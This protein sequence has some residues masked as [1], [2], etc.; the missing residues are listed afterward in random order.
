MKLF[1]TG[2][3]LLICLA[4]H[5]QGIFVVHFDFNKH[6]LTK[7]SRLQLDSLLHAHGPGLQEYLIELQGHC[8]A[9]GSGRY[10][11]WLSEKRINTVRQYLVT[12][13]TATHFANVKAY[14]ERV[15]LNSNATAGERQLNRRVEISLVKINPTG[16]PEPSLKEKIADSSTT[17]GTNIVLRNINFVGGMHEFLPSSSAALQELRDAMRAYPTLVIEVQ[18]HIC[19]EPGD[20]DGTD[21][22]TGLPNLSE[23]RAKAVQDF[24]IKNGI[25]PG[26]ITYKGFGHS[27]PLYIYPEKTEE[28]KIA[29]RRVEI[30]I[31]KK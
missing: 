25:G 28:E 17:P 31:V 22:G 14:G 20:K 13:G 6:S 11:Q 9:I 3:V 15:P 8:D 30:R 10:N 18:G 21:L 12:H 27:T 26:R 19:C 16:L 7:K 2:I 24:L 1:F 5:T 23:A 29:N 4:C